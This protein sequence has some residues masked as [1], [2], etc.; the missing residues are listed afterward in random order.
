MS[1]AITTIK[2]KALDLGLK[3]IT[4]KDLWIEAKKI[5]DARLR[6]PLFCL[7]PDFKIL[8]MTKANTIT[9]AWWEEVVNYYVTP[10]ISGLFVK[11]SGLM[12][13]NSR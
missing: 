4:D 8:L 10:P 2:D 11:E 9:S 5:I 6:C 1:P 12:G 3:D 7:G 13:R